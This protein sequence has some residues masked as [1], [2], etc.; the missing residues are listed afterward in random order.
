M[1]ESEGLKEGE[2]GA[3]LMDS[4]S[5]VHEQVR[6]V[7]EMLPTCCLGSSRQ[8]QQPQAR[9]GRGLDTEM[10]SRTRTT[11]TR[12]IVRVSLFDRQS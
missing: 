6:M 12:V 11:T 10:S 5:C 1:N 3:Y 7:N 8:L 4:E 9:V 2:R